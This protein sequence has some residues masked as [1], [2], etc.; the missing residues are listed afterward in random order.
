MKSNYRNIGIL[1]LA[2]FVVVSASVSVEAA[3]THQGTEN[4]SHESDK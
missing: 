1:V 3:A 2:S 4:F